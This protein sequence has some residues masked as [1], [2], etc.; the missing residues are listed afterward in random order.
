MGGKKELYRARIIVTI[1]LWVLVLVLV[2]VVVIVVIILLGTIV[3][4]LAGWATLVIII[5]SL[6]R[7]NVSVSIIEIVLHERHPE[8]AIVK[9]RRAV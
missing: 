7:R 2:I 9:T 3:I 1:S 8:T 6:L 5:V 4:G